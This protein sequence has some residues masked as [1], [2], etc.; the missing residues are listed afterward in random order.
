MPLNP[1]V[2]RRLPELVVLPLGLLVGSWCM[3]STRTRDGV[4][5]GRADAPVRGLPTDATD[6]NYHLAPPASYCDFRTS[7]AGFVE[8]AA[9]WDLPFDRRDGGP[10]LAHRWDHAAG[11][12]AEVEIADGVFFAWA[13]MDASRGL[14]F[15]RRTGR[16]YCSG[17]YR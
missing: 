10:G 15:D 6:C 17:S 11:R 13:K 3:W 12:V 7:E 4:G 14:A 2:R 1:W 8:F 16:A 5:V 9:A